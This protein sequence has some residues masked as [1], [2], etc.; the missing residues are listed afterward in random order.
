[1]TTY[2]S[3][4]KPLNTKVEPSNIAL[5]KA[6]TKE[7]RDER[8]RKGL[9]MWCGV[10]YSYNHSCARSQLYQLLVDDVHEKYAE[11]ADCTSEREV[12]EEPSTDDTNRGLKTVIFLHAL[13]GTGD[14][15]T[16]RV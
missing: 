4:T 8:K 1:M 15:L 3:Y 2:H 6:S 5:A 7:E 14:S 11:Y 10:K 9:C 13:L 12:R 16:M